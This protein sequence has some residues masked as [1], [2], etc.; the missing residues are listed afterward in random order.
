MNE[1]QVILVIV[2]GPS[3]EN[4][5]GGILKEYFYSEEVQFAVVRG[6]ITSRSSIKPENVVRNVKNLVEQ[7]KIRYGYN[8]HDI[9]RIIHIA[10]M[11]GAFTENCVHKADVKKIRYCED[12]IEASDV[13]AIE[14]R[15]RSK[16]KVLLTLYSTGKIRGIPYRIHFNSCNLEHVLYNQLNDFSDEEKEKLSDEFADRFEGKVK[17]F[18]GFISDPVFAAPGTYRE[19]WKYIEKDRHSLERHSNMHLIFDGTGR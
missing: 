1:K 16:A 4:A 10:D 9:I 2:E 8:W 18:I 13:E 7:V 15:N 19:T 5:L 12:H 17:E 3:D 6:D 14:K 11:D